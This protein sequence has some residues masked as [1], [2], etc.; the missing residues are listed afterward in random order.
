MT[1]PALPH[2]I[3]RALRLLA[4]RGQPV[5]TADLVRHLFGAVSGPWERLLPTVLTDPRLQRLPD[6]RWTLA[7]AVAP[8]ARWVA[9]ALATSGP[10]PERHHI[11]GI[12]ALRGRGTTVEA[13]FAHLV[14]P[15]RPVR[16]PAYL[17]RQGITP[18]A[19]ATAPTFAEIAPALV[20]F[21]GEALLVGL[22]IGLQ[23]AF[24][25]AELRRAGLPPLTNPL[26]DLA[27]LPALAPPVS[28]KPRLAHLT[29]LAGVAPPADETLSAQAEAIA[30]L[31]QRHPPTRPVGSALQATRRR[32]LLTPALAREIPPGP[33]LYVFTDAAGTV[34]YIGQSRNL[35]QRVHSYLTRNLAIAR[36]LHGLAD[37][38]AAIRVESTSCALEAALREAAA[39]ATL[40]PPFNT[41]RRPT[42]PT[43]DLVL[44]LTRRG[45][46]RLVVQR[47]PATGI[48]LAGPLPVPVARHLAQR[49]TQ[50]DHAAL[51]ATGLAR[52]TTPEAGRA[53]LLELAGDLPVAGPVPLAA[54]TGLLLVV[55]EGRTTA[56]L[57]LDWQGLWGGTPVRS[58]DQ[59]ATTLARL[60]PPALTPAARAAQFSRLYRWLSQTER[61][62]WAAVGPLPAPVERLAQ[63]LRR[64]LD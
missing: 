28:G 46:P 22:D 39:I 42:P 20:D 47:A 24:L 41:V 59:A 15:P 23:V 19:L 36:R 58:P 44:R 1:Q 17:A 57:L 43:A 27:A 14:R 53:L 33:G 5:S 25:Q 7:E 21:L 40:Q 37:R 18:T 31:L 8:P 50:A 52:L 16:L 62:C 51:A 54:L 29:A 4:E 61:P 56:A 45:Q 49:L 48:V 2:L 3:E 30:R 34:L 38:V 26:A 11:V 12:A 55:R 6:G 63:A 9:L 64:L 32:L 35:R 60:G 13:R 10:K